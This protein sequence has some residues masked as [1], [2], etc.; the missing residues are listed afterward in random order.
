MNVEYLCLLVPECGDERFAL[1]FVEVLHAFAQGDPG[2]PIHAGEEPGVHHVRTVSTHLAE[3]P[4]DGF[5]DQQ[6]GVLQ[7]RIRLPEEPAGVTVGRDH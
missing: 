6:F 7:Q 3:H 4:A 1:R 2:D 5:P